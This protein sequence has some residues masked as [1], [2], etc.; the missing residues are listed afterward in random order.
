MHCVHVHVDQ[1]LIKLCLVSNEVFILYNIF[2]LAKTESLLRAS[3]QII[4]T[5]RSSKGY[6][7]RRGNGGD[8]ARSVLIDV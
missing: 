1:C 7:L 6:I 4:S 2:S 5:D 8:I 3:F